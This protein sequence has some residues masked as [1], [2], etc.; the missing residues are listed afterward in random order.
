MCDFSLEAYNSRAAQAD[1]VLT[2]TRMPSGCIGL[3][4]SEP[5]EHEALKCLACV[6]EGTIL[7]LEIPSEDF[8]FSIEDVLV[9]KMTPTMVYGGGYYRDAVKTEDGTVV[10]FQKLRLRTSV[11]VLMVADAKAPEDKPLASDAPA[12]PV[13]D[14]GYLG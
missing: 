12:T 1:D 8:G 9:T 3:A 13:Y 14:Y 2:V 6:T 11:K 4:T 5:T 7:R 10:S